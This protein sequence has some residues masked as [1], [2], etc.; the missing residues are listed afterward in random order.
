MRG[1][2]EEFGSVALSALLGEGAVG[3][4]Q[5]MLLASLGFSLTETKQSRSTLERLCFLHPN[6]FGIPGETL[7]PYLFIQNSRIQIAA[8]H[9]NY[10]GFQSLKLEDYC[11]IYIALLVNDSSFW[12]ITL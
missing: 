12:T 4:A 8:P 2:E 7:T 3:R 5:L 11:G 6:H 9:D 1:G 10:C